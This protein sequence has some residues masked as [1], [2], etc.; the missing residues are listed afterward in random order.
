[1]GAGDR[2][3]KTLR[4][5]NAG[6]GQTGG[7]AGEAGRRRVSCVQSWGSPSWGSPSWKVLRKTGAGGA[8]MLAV[9]QMEAS[10]GGQRQGSWKTRH[11][12]GDS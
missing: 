1:M 7:K 11:P 9:M 10:S 4:R 8:R 6:K 2:P 5:L 3:E 12:R